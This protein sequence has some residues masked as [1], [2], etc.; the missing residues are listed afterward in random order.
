MGNYEE[1]KTAVA[2]VIK[3]NGNE[4]ITGQIMQ[5]TLLSMISN[6][7]A[8]STFAGVATPKTAPGTPDQNVFYLAGTPGVYANFGGYEL[9]QGIVMFTNASGAFT[10]VDLGFSNDNLKRLFLVDKSIIG[11]PNID[12]DHLYN[13]P[14]GGAPG[15]YIDNNTFDT[16][17][18]IVPIDSGYMSVSGANI[19]RVLFFSDINPV[20]ANLINTFTTNFQLIPIPA[21][22]KLALITLSKANNPEGYKNLR[23]SQPGAAATRSDVSLLKQRLY[24]NRSFSGKVDIDA[25]ML[26]NIISGNVNY[27]PNTAFDVAFV[28]I[29][30]KSKY[31]EI[32]GATIV[33]VSFFSDYEINTANYISNTTNYITTIPSNAVMATITLRKTDN[34]D[35]YNN[36]R[37]NQ[38]GAAPSSLRL[39]QNT[40]ELFTEKSLFFNRSGN[41]ITTTAYLT[42]TGFLPITGKDDIVV[43]GANN[44]SVPAIT[45]WDA[46]YK[47]IAPIAQ[48]KQATNRVYTVAAADIPAGAKYIRCTRNENED[49]DATS[50]YIVGVNIAA[51]LSMR[52]NIIPEFKQVIT[53][54]NLIN[55]AN[56]LRGITYSSSTGLITSADGI[57]SNKLRLSPGTYTIK[58]VAPY[59]N[60]QTTVRILRFNDKNEMV[61]ADAIRLDANKEGHYTVTAG[62]S[63]VGG[64]GYIDYWRIVLQFDTN[65]LFDPTV[66]QFEKNSVAT[67]FEPCQT[68]LIENPAYNLTPRM[69][70][71]T[72][73]SSSMPGNGYFETACE[74]LGFKHRNEAISGDSVML[75]ATRAWR[76]LIY[77]ADGR[78]TNNYD[79]AGNFVGLYTFEELENIDIFVT[80]HIHNYDV[81]FEGKVFE[82]VET[83]FGYYSAT[84][85]FAQSGSWALDKY[86]LSPN[87]TK[88]IVNSVTIDSQT[89]HALFFDRNNNFISGDIIFDPKPTTIMPIIDR[90]IDVPENAAY[91][92]IK[93]Y[94]FPGSIT[95]VRGVGYGILQKTVAEY[96][97]KGYDANNNPLTVP[98]NKTDLTQRIVPYG[99]QG[100]PGAQV[101]DNLYDERYAAGYDYLLKKYALD[102]Y[103]LRLNP[104]SKY[105]GTKSG[106][107]V[108]IVCTTQW[109]DGYVRFNEGVKKMAKRHGAI[110]CNVA[111]NVGFSYLQTDPT[112]DDSIR[113]GALHCNNA[114]IGSGNDTE[115]IPIH[116]IMYTGMG[117]HPTR[118]WDS[119]IQMKRAQIL[120][121]TMRLATYNNGDFGQII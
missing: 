10:A 63:G 73:A 99:G 36:L 101:P 29:F 14:E 116:G 43:K 57:L 59:A 100:A 106:K 46:H 67:D 40:G 11:I 69:A 21:T 53:G 105:Y 75:H 90:E 79:N 41:P 94:Y 58:G 49:A 96:E 83:T 55:P 74:L 104:D 32:T 28:D 25:N 85:A 20:A 66:A 72:G 44:A 17:W 13:I 91:V 121:E 113:W 81:A 6:I 30:D 102:C 51:L 80:S 23:V 16:G 95:M 47:F 62:T 111:D 24:K 65:V 115:T 118:Q 88:L 120:A 42:T 119:Y 110:V 45:F 52:E 78:M 98:M 92:L 107:P 7:G 39:L 34:T 18:A 26:V 22:A 54:K 2:A 50:S 76:G 4:E 103:N 82:R 117:W 19:T 61:Y 48:T 109:H 56:L 5:N 77:E 93:R 108:V 35:G 9:K 27:I 1:L 15:S 97:A 112:N 70:F 71:M 60:V 87:D 86:N 37:V 38:N 33:R 3:Q 89:P 114:A 31:L 12:Y 64:N 84:G 68:K 8:N